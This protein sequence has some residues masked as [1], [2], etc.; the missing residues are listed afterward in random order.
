MKIFK[1]Q[2]IHK[3]I[4]NFAVKKQL[5]IEHTIE[6]FLEKY[7]ELKET[8]DK[9]DRYSYVNLLDNNWVKFTSFVDYSIK[10]A[11]IIGNDEPLSSEYNNRMKTI[12]K[13]Y[14]TLSDEEKQ[15]WTKCESFRHYNYESIIAKVLA[16]KKISIGRRD[17]SFINKAK[18][19]IPR[20]NKLKENGL[21]ETF[22]NYKDKE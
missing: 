11:N 9:K 13:E 1:N 18:Q 19:N 7:P 12:K 6:L 16:T 2:L 10:K 14:Q 20:F 15:F 5:D 21:L 22:L 3:G 4:I 8:I 17:D